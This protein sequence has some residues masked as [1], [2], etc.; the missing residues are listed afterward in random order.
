MPSISI[1][2]VTLNCAAALPQLIESLRMQ[3]DQ[4]FQWVVFDGG[5]TDSTLEII[6][7][8]PAAYLTLLSGRDFGIYDA[9]NK[10]IQIADGD[11]YLV[12]GGDDTLKPDAIS[13]FRRRA[14]ETNAD[15]VAASIQAGDIVLKPLEGQPW[16]RGGNAYIAGHAVGTLIRRSLHSHCGYYSNR[17]VN[18][19]DM[20][21]I[22]TALMRGK[23]TLAAGNFVAGR[24][25]TAGVSTTDRVCSLSDA[26]RI[27][28]AFGENKYVQL[29]LFLIRLT[30]S[31]LL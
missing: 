20:H 24:F 12:L 17:Y 25:G 10:A 9:L 22:L 3:D 6:A 26:F 1:V 16:R 14:V 7:Q 29:C 5:S 2:S 8:Y 11:Y 13:S 21:F 19:A 23:A 27:Q 30:R 4:D 31:V 15:L 18:C 28:L